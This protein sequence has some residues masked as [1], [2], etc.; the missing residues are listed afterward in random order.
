MEKCRVATTNWMSQRATVFHYMAKRRPS[1]NRGPPTI[2]QVKQTAPQQQQERAID[3]GRYRDAI[4]EGH[5][6]PDA[7]PPGASR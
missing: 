6:S 2:R 4:R 1:K 3:H 5:V 7:G